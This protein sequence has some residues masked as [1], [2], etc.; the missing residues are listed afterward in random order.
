MADELYRPS[1][2]TEGADFIGAWCG[3]C[4]AD[5]ND[6]CPILANSFCGPV[7][8]WTYERGEPVCTAF[9]AID[10][11]NV[12]HMRS[13]AVRDMFPAAPRRPSQGEQ[14]RALITNQGTAQ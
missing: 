5:V 13:A 7:D 1:S 4:K 8:E 6:D 2:G 14:I 12:P 10:P 11:L 9:D 3:R